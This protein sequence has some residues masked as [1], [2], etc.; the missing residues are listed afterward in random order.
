MQMPVHHV[1][2]LSPDP[3]DKHADQR[4][5]VNLRFNFQP[6]AITYPKS[7]EDV[8]RIVKIGASSGLKVVARSGGV[9]NKNMFQSKFY[10]NDIG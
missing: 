8:S 6:A 9:S 10:T 1:C 5:A 4:G 7:P 3:L 2:Y